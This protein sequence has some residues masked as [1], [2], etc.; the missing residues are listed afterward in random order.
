MGQPHTNTRGWA[1]VGTLKFS[2]AFV[3]VSFYYFIP[4]PC[5][6]SQRLLPRHPSGPTLSSWQWWYPSILLRLRQHCLSLSAPHPWQGSSLR[7][8]G[9]WVLR[10]ELGGGCSCCW[11]VS[12][13]RNFQNYWMSDKFCR[14]DWNWQLTR[15][16][17]SSDLH[18]MWKFCMQLYLRKR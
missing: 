11:V 7:V 9:I 13:I 1:S 2:Y 16:S 12:D 6:N 15:D 14:H 8:C 18:W 10:M 3:F 5:F 17:A 4:W